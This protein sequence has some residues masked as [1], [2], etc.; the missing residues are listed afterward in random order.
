VVRLDI[1]K[2]TGHTI[3]GYRG[4]EPVLR[5]WGIRCKKWMLGRT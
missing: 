3:S 5:R 2:K 1:K 4:S